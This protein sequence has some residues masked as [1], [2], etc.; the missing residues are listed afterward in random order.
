MKKWTSPTPNQATLFLILRIIRC[1]PL[2]YHYRL[3]RLRIVIVQPVHLC[4]P[5]EHL[6]H[7]PHA[8]LPA[9][10]VRRR[11][12]ILQ[13]S[14]RG[15]GQPAD[16]LRVARYTL[17]R[18]CAVSRQIQVELEEQLCDFVG[19]WFRLG[20]LCPG[21]ALTQLP[22]LHAAL[23]EAVTGHFRIVVQEVAL[24]GVVEVAQL[25]EDRI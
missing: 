5:P 18:L 23:G 20:K 12:A 9:R 15:I 10:K 22:D 16:Q 24:A 1:H 2:S 13:C 17:H 21:C 25:F 7:L 14:E 19:E 6:R 8:R 4:L 3:Q 11:H